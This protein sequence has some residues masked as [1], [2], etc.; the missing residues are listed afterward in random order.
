LIRR[1]I[2]QDLTPGAGVDD[3][4]I[5]APKRWK[6]R[7]A[8]KVVNQILAEL[9]LSQHPDKTFIGRIEQGLD[10]L[11][12]AFSAAGLVVGGGQAVIPRLGADEGRD[13]GTSLS[14]Y[15]DRGKGSKKQDM[16]PFS[17]LKIVTTLYDVQG[18]AI[19]VE[20]ELSGIQASYCESKRAWPL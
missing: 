12:Y 4:V 9:R 8:I 19:E 11:G 1:K 17:L 18:N 3:W 20:A 7:S 14:T 16:T 2:R 13:A 10:F 15:A 6:L 5:L